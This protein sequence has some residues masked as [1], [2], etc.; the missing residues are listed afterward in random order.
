MVAG[1][2]VSEEIEGD[3]DGDGVDG[4]EVPGL[5]L[6]FGDGGV[7]LTEEED[8]E[9]ADGG[10]DDGE[11]EEEVGGAV[12]EEGGAEVGEDSCGEADIALEDAGDGAS[13]LAEVSDAGD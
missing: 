5:A 10:G 3:D 11:H 12:G 7:D 4:G 9:D 8:G 2:I 13:V 1:D 6:V